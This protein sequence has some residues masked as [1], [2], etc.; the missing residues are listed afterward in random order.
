MKSL[1]EVFLV[2][3]LFITNALAFENFKKKM[4]NILED[5]ENIDKDIDRLSQNDIEFYNLP[6]KVKINSTTY[7]TKLFF[8]FN[9]SPKIFRER[10][11]ARLK[12]N[13]TL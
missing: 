3:H 2:V 5:Y 7:F 12:R 13:R 9:K 1:I 11:E 10:K 6:D 4:T 8:I